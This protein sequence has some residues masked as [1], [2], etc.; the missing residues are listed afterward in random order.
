MTTSTVIDAHS[1]CGTSMPVV[2]AMDTSRASATRVAWKMRAWR[3][4]RS[5]S[6]SALVVFRRASSMGAIT[7]GGAGRL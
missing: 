3:N 5:G 2:S 6:N 1:P 7:F 4:R